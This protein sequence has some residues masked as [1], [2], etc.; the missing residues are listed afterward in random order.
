MLSWFTGHRHCKDRCNDC[1]WPL[2]PQVHVLKQHQK[3]F[4]LFS[5]EFNCC[6]MIDFSLFSELA[7]KVEELLRLKENALIRRKSTNI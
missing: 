3:L 5:F 1:P 7:E 4:F 2:V 6:L